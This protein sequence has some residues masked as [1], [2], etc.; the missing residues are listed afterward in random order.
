MDNQTKK[1]L[2]SSASV[3]AM[4]AGVACSYIMLFLTGFVLGISFVLVFFAVYA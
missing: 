2:D 3:E 1:A 4:A